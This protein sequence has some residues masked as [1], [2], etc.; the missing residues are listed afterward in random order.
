M[1]VDEKNL[2]AETEGKVKVRKIE[3]ER[4]RKVRKERERERE[5]EV[6]RDRQRVREKIGQRESLYCEQVRLTK[7]PHSRPS[8]HTHTHTHTHTHAKDT[9]F[10]QRNCVS[11][12]VQECVSVCKLISVLSRFSVKTDSSFIYLFIYLSTC[13]DRQIRPSGCV[14]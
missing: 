1:K 4:S 5:R 7:S 14:C 2:N 11:V 9:I 13:L 3:L 12:C 6:R 10:S 8:S